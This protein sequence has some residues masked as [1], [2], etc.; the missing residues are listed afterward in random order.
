PKRSSIAIATSV[1]QTA[2]LNGQRRIKELAAVSAIAAICSTL[3]A[4]AMLLLFGEGGIVAFVLAGPIAVFFL[5]HIYTIRDRL[6]RPQSRA[7]IGAAKLARGGVPLMIAALALPLGVLAVRAILQSELGQAA[8]GHF[9]AAWVISSLYVGLVLNS[10]SADYFPR[11]S[12]AIHDHKT[13]NRLVNEQT[14]IAL[15]VIAPAFLLLMGCASFVVRILYSSEFSEAVFVLRWQLLG[16]ALKVVSWPLGFILLASGDGKKLI[17]TEYAAVSAF[18]ALSWIGV[19]VVG[20]QGV[21]GA[22]LGM[23]LAYTPL[24]Y[25]VGRKKTGFAWSQSV[26]S[27]LAVII[28]WLLLILAASYFSN[29]LAA[30]L[31]IASAAVVGLLNLRK[32]DSLIELPGVL[33]NIAQFRIANIH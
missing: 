12:A 19:I 24:I 20:I 7:V 5:G 3:V 21:G 9:H 18:I 29:W 28:S 27:A 15:L 25:W 10:M 1:E 6:S 31:G 11:L 22:F 8:S 14:E 30:S 13:A 4:I 26:K 23:Y 33:H 16:D 17:Y 32:L 2:V